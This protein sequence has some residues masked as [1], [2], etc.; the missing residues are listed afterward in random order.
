M[1]NA[2]ILKLARLFDNYGEV[3]QHRAKELFFIGFL[4]GAAMSASDRHLQEATRTEG[5]PLWPCIEAFNRALRNGGWETASIASDIRNGLLLGSNL[6]VGPAIISLGVNL[7]YC[8]ILWVGAAAL[9]VVAAPRLTIYPNLDFLLWPLCA[10]LTQAVGVALV[11]RAMKRRGCK[12]A[13]VMIRNFGMI[14]GSLAAIALLSLWLCPALYLVCVVA[15]FSLD[16]LI[17]R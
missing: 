17:R 14:A 2:C 7:A 5:I 16:W 6:L 10:G 8:A 12:R 13:V 9:V 3:V 4:L 11:F 15:Q 1:A